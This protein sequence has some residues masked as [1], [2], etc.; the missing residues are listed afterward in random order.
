MTGTIDEVTAMAELFNQ[1]TY[2]KA[3]VIDYGKQVVTMLI[4]QTIDLDICGQK[5]VIYQNFTNHFTAV[6]YSIQK[7]PKIFLIPILN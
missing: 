2:A 4:Y 5:N 6:R 7:I 1:K 3:V